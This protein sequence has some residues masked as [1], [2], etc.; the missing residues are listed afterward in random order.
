M[1][2]ELRT[3]RLANAKRNVIFGLLKQLLS[4]GLLFTIRTVIIY[5]L[6]AEYQGLNNLFSSI[7]QVLNLSDLGFNAAA[8]FI[9]YKPIAEDDFPTINA[10]ASYL[11]KVYLCI[12]SIVLLVGLCIIP[13]LPKLISGSYPS[14]INIYLLFG[15]YLFESVSSYFFFGYKSTILVAYQREDIVSNVYSI[16]NVIIRIIQIV[17]LL[18][19]KNYWAYAALLP[20]AA[21]VNNLILNIISKRAFPKL[22][23]QG[24]IS[25]ETKKELVKQV[26]AVFVNR[27]SDVARN[28]FDSI[29]LS[30]F[31]GL[32]IVS[33]YGNYFYIF[34]A[35]YGIIGIFAR[36]I[37]A[38]VGNSIVTETVE[39]NNRNFIQVTF[40]FMWIVGECSICLACLFQPFM[41]IWMKGNT[42]LIISDLN[43]YLFCVYFYCLSA[44]YPKNVYLEAKGLFFEC[45]WLYLLEAIFNLGFNVLLGYFFGMTG[46]LL[47]TII[48]VVAFNYIGGSQV[49]FKHYLKSSPI[50]YYF[51]NILYTAV[52]GTIMAGMV[53]L[54]KLISIQ[55]IWGFVIKTVICLIV[56]NVL[57]G[58]IYFRSQVFKDSVMMA[59]NMIKKK[60]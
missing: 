18:L 52:T 1:R 7:L 28:S 41:Q 14:D 15:V 3:N 29:I 57:Y 11:K 22:L 25:I 58:I 54:V 32:I 5:V 53:C 37:K 55:G 31:F 16:V 39:K 38:G 19:V 56:P 27:L 45:R 4:I 8:A 46:V 47:A 35:I 6:G 21:I 2:N 10:I 59:K 44:T 17:L 13:F 34:S 9:L 40:I 24:T 36:A 48:T 26:K 51:N 33:S 60:R 43:M 30:L 23:P 49:L 20:A 12:G 42:E 50:R